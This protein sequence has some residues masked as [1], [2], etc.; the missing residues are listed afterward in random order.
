MRRSLESGLRLGVLQVLRV[1]RV[2]LFVLSAGRLEVCLGDFFDGLRSSRLEF[3]ARPGPTFVQRTDRRREHG[4]C[5]RCPASRTSLPFQHVS[6]F[7]RLLA[8]HPA[9]TA[10]GPSPQ[11]VRPRKDLDVH[12]DRAGNFRVSSGPGARRPGVATHPKSYHQPLC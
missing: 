8:A 4:L 6:T 5:L 10:L 11:T 3:H 9:N 1:L 12:V 7:Q 2:L